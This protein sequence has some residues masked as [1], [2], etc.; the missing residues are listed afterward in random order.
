MPS[1]PT[2]RRADPMRVI[3]LL[4]LEEINM[5]RNVETNRTAVIAQTVSLT[6]VGLFFL[7]AFFHALTHREPTDASASNRLS[8]SEIGSLPGYPGIPQP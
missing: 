3:D 4:L 5:R 6:A 7:A 8:H 1:N 2:R